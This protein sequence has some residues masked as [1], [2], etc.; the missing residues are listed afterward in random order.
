MIECKYIVTLFILSIFYYSY[1]K[2]KALPTSI[3]NALFSIFAE[4]IAIHLKFFASIRAM[5]DCFPSLI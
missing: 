3:D 1:I 4:F 5:P 2:N